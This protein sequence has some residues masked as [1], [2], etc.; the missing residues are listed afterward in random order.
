MQT[1]VKFGLTKAGIISTLHT[2][3][4]YG[5]RSIGSIGIF[6]PFLIQGIGRIYI[7]IKHY[8]GSNPYIPLLRD[9]LANLKL[10]AGK[11]GR[12]LEMDTQ[13]FKN[14]YRQSPGYSRYGNSCSQ[15]K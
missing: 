7:L 8:W 12:I 4:R 14:G 2:A 6:D 10:E 13:K 1:I 5:R 15:T 11:E 9:N 3:V